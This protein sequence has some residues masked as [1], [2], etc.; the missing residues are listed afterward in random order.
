MFSLTYPATVLHLIWMAWLLLKE[1]HIRLFISKDIKKKDDIEYRST[2]DL[3]MTD[4]LRL[5]YVEIS[6]IVETYHLGIKQ[7]CGIERCQA[8][9]ERA[10]RNHIEMALRAFLRQGYLLV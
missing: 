3:K 2:N 5:K 1:L 7:F 8:R 4:L 10:Q 9:S 6:W